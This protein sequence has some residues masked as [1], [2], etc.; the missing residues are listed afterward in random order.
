MLKASTYKPSRGCSAYFALTSTVE[1]GS[2]KINC[3]GFAL[4]EGTRSPTGELRNFKHGIGALVG[5]R[6]VSVV[7]CYL[8]GTFNAWPKGRRLPRPKKIRLV[9]GA[10]RSYA[11]T[12]TDRRNNGAIA[13]ELHDAVLELKRVA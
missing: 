4:N 8:E 13:A 2:W 11:V 9:V 6:D 12:A 5:G 10:P 3:A 7:P 1:R